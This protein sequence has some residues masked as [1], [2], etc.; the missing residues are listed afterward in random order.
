MALNLTSTVLWIGTSPKLFGYDL[1]DNIIANPPK[2]E[3][4]LINSY[5]F[6]YNFEGILH[7]SPYMEGE[8]LF[9]V[10]KIINS[11]I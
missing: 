1:H 11:L 9:S 8:D 6:D 10:E 5:L 4:K 3:P 2:N 7:E